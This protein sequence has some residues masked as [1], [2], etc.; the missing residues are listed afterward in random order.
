V[1]NARIRLI[2]LLIVGLSGPAFAQSPAGPVA[3]PPDVAIQPPPP[4]ATVK[5]RVALVTTPA[6]VRNSKG[7]M[8]HDLEASDFTVTD[9]GVPQR[10]THFDL[11]GDPLS[12]LVLIENSSLVEPMLPEIRKSGILISQTVMGPNAEAAVVAFNEYTEKLLDFTASGDAVEKTIATLKTSVSGNK[13]YDSMARAVEMLSGRP[14]PTPDAPGRRRILLI[15]AEAKDEGSD[16][17]LGEVL[18]KAQLANVT[19]YSVGLSTTRA[20]LQRKAPDAGHRSQPPGTLGK[21]PFP[22]SVQTPDND[23]ATYGSGNIL[24]A[25]VWA[26]TRVQDAL[27]DNPLQI[28][29]VGTGGAHLATFKDRS[30]QNAIDEIGGELH[31]QYSLSY[32]PTGAGTSGYH[33][34][35]VTVDKKKLKVRARPGYYLA[36][37]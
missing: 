24:A 6:T 5:V 23:A 3:P 34:I 37:N 19:I 18:R 13:L 21:P 26:V 1:P 7:E 10:I 4:Q 25:V 11:G 14:E 17:R 12:I 32:T 8:I 29:T 27:K 28:A 9:N 16:A 15:I 30:I 35:K 22:G 36:E 31:S 33:E 2:L 20:E